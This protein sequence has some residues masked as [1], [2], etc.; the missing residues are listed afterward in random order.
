MGWGSCPEYLSLLQTPDSSGS[1]RGWEDVLG[2]LYL[3][4]APRV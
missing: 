3:L 1:P 2:S 4:A